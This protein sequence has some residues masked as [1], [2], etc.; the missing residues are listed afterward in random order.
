MGHEKEKEDSLRILAAKL[1]DL[2]K[3]GSSLYY[4]VDEEFYNEFEKNEDLIYGVYVQFKNSQKVKYKKLLTDSFYKKNKSYIN[5][6][7]KGKDN[8]IFERIMIAE[9]MRNLLLDI[10]Q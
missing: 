1:W 6:T 2:Q 7:L 8:N 10:S 9:E 3:I 4:H 5:Q